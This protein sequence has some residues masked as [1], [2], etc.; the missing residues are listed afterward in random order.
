MK[1][2]KALK[3]PVTL[4]Q[5]KAEPSLAEIKLLRQSRL[6]VMPLEAAEFEKIVE[7]SAKA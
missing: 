6:S 4:E 7:L 2:V 3:H 1:P 5:I